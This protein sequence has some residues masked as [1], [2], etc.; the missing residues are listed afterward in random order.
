M[1]AKVYS[2]N[3]CGYCDAAKSL[4]KNKN[5]EF[6]EV[7]LTGDDDGKF[8]LVKKTGQRTFPQIFLDGNF[9]GG[10]TDLK[11]FLDSKGS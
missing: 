7:N 3:N 4:L 1:K 5:I 10:Y 6:E 2:I 11:S 9:V 8:E